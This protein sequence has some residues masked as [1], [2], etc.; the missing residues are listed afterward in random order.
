MQAMKMQPT[1][2]QYR[3]DDPTGQ[4]GSSPHS[5]QQA[6]QRYTPHDAPQDAQHGGMFNRAFDLALSAQRPA[7]LA[8][9]RSVRLRHPDAAPDQLV[10]S[11]ERRYLTLVTTAGAS[12]GAVAAIPAVGTATTLVISGA[13]TVGFLELTAL[14]AQSVAEVHG[15]AVDDPDRARTLVMALMLGGEASG[16]I[17]Q[18]GRQAT[19]G[20]GRSA[21]WGEL[22]TSQLPRAVMGPLTDQLKSKFVR[23]FGRRG[24]ASF[25]GKA[26]PFGVGAAIGGVGN[27]LLG[28]RVVKASRGAFG[29]TPLLVP[30]HF[31]PKEGAVTLERRALDTARRAIPKRKSRPDARE[32]DEF[33]I[34]D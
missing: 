33:G 5:A 29:E 1:N 19:G 21:Y 34:T 4:Y 13:E 26:M 3:G 20:P 31:E 28:R 32:A 9:L 14:F 12:V 11:L 16:L 6:L 17:A 23:E 15:I 10:R 22:I 18:L 8:H 25:V 2:E 7:V 30:G 27:N 24:G